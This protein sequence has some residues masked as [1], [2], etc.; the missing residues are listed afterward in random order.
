MGDLRKAE[1]LEVVICI[2][3]SNR[4]NDLETAR[5]DER[6]RE[7]DKESSRLYDRGN[8]LEV[9]KARLLAHPSSSHT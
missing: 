1:A 8:A 4:E 5:L 6:I 7:L 3:R 2:L 9:E